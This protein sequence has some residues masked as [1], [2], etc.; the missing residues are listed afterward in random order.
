[1]GEVCEVI[2]NIL[3]EMVLEGVLCVCGI[4]GPLFRI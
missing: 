3:C 1:M 2:E 4:G